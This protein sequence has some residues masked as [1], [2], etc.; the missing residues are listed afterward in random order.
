MV[1]AKNDTASEALQKQIKE[2]SLQR[3]YLALVWG[4]LPNSA[5]LIDHPMARHPKDRKKMAVQQGGRVAQTRYRVITESGDHSL[6]MLQLITGR[7]HQIRVHLAS[8]GHPVI[9]DPIYGKRK[10]QFGL[11]TQALHSSKLC[12]RHPYNQE[13]LCW[14]HAP[15]Q[16][17]QNVIQKLNMEFDFAKEVDCSDYQ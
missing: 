12:L 2:Q 17:F 4:R 16:E 5:G 15:P 8:I 1:V 14:S 13:L 7:T 6:L 11:L 9:G 3:Y 10:N